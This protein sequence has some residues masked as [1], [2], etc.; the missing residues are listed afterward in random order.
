MS[1]IWSSS[2]RPISVKTVWVDGI[3]HAIL[4]HDDPFLNIKSRKR[5]QTSVTKNKDYPNKFEPSKSNSENIENFLNKNFL[6][7][8]VAVEKKQPEKKLEQNLIRG[9]SAPC[10]KTSSS[11]HSDLQI[12]SI[13]N[14]MK[15]LK[16]EI[17]D[18]TNY[19]Y[20]E[21]LF[22]SDTLLSLRKLFDD[23]FDEK[24]P[25]K[26]KPSR[27]SSSINRD[28]NESKSDLTDS[29]ELE[30]GQSNYLSERVLQWLDLSGKVRNYKNEKVVSSKELQKLKENSGVNFIRKNIS[31]SISNQSYNLEEEEKEMET[32]KKRMKRRLFKT[33]D[34]QDT[35]SV[36]EFESQCFEDLLKADLENRGVISK[37]VNT[38]KE[39][40]WTPPRKR[41]LHIFMPS[42][43]SADIYS[44]QESLLYD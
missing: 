32:M 28:S 11:R 19:L 23:D 36:G 9:Q 7:L 35:V 44:S 43:K 1:P 22:Q 26:K 21:D 8:R 14:L 31:A 15:N 6:N 29:K 3:R 37:V 18:K 41:E 38:E 34:F 40:T 39:A 33:K 24:I 2:E 27:I 10:S 16:Q 4:S 13:L 25:L 42:L 5:P 17:K 30:E 20:E 12:N